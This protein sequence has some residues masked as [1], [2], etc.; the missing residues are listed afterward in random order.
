MAFNTQEMST[1]DKKEGPSDWSRTVAIDVR[2]E[3]GNKLARNDTYQGRHLIR[4]NS[5]I[6]QG[7]Y[8]GLTA[9]EAIVVDFE[10]DKPLQ[11]IF[12]EAWLLACEYFADKSKTRQFHLL[13]AVFDT[14]R[15]WF[16]QTT[17][18]D[19]SACFRHGHIAL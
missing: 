19:L 4:H 7:V 5:Q 12:E 13:K 2:L 11:K 15:Q 18:D 3:K 10:H 1:D 9:R 8:L 16:R 6:N 14:V 17:E